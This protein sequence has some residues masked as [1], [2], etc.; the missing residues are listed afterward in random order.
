MRELEFDRKKLRERMALAGESIRHLSS[1]AGLARSTVEDLLGQVKRKP[2]GDTLQHLGK[3]LR[4]SVEDLCTWQDVDE[5][6]VPLDPP[7]DRSCEPQDAPVAPAH[8]HEASLLGLLRS[9]V[10]TIIVGDRPA[11]AARRSSDILNAF[12][13]TDVA[14]LHRVLSAT[15]H[16]VVSHHAFAEERSMSPSHESVFRRHMLSIGAGDV[17]LCSFYLNEGAVFRFRV[18]EASRA[19]LL[20]A[21]GDLEELDGNERITYLHEKRESLERLKREMSQ[22]TFFDPFVGETSIKP[23]HEYGVVSLARLDHGQPSILA[24]GVTGA[25][26]AG[27]V[28]LLSGRAILDQ[29][30]GR[31]AGIETRP[32]G[33]VFHRVHLH[34][35]NP[36]DILQV[37]EEL[38]WD[39]P[40]Y[41]MA[42]LRVKLESMKKSVPV[43]LTMQDIDRFVALVEEVSAAPLPVPQT[44]LAVVLPT[45]GLGSRMT[46]VTKGK[47]SK[48]ALTLAEETTVLD[49]CTA[50]FQAHA[51]VGAV[52]YLTTKKFLEDQQ[53]VACRRSREGC[54]VDVVLEGH[55]GFARSLLARLMAELERRRVAIVGMPDV[56]FEREALHAFLDRAMLPEH[57]VLVGHSRAIPREARNYGVVRLQGGRVVS[58]IEKPGE[59]NDVTV[60][61]GLFAFSPVLASLIRT[62]T[63]E[64]LLTELVTW[65]SSRDRTVV[66][67]A[68]ERVWD[69]G[70]P[71]GYESAIAAFGT[72][73]PHLPEADRVG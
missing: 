26:T 39:T 8:G 14:W 66:G 55:E 62:Y 9:C 10:F 61:C 4:C 43:H 13:W 33:G 46:V 69:C 47:N 30:T 57:D 70:D 27:A 18:D 21:F 24:A 59:P 48:L 29:Q 23:G 51:R 32:A 60:S 28:A 56:L 19:D 25:T 15:Q 16:D 50:E 34:R 64:P 2:R 42:D 3:V 63:G 45:G 35:R 53:L 40:A 22:K 7:P 1:E 54:P 71:T 65:L 5:R 41:T 20:M 17:N 38:V 73:R 6:S 52:S 44:T 67:H 72:N 58:M 68:F 37:H 36:F 31:P 49:F 11:V 12:G